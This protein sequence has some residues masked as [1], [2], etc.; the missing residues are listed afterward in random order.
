MEPIPAGEEHPDTRLS[1]GHTER[2]RTVGTHTCGQFEAICVLYVLVL[3]LQQEAGVPKQNPG[4]RRNNIQTPCEKAPRPAG[5]LTTSSEATMPT[6]ATVCHTKMLLIF[7]KK[8]NTSW[9]YKRENGH[10]IFG[11]AFKA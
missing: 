8:L 7:I 2:Q 5:E 6:T 1:Q 9:V 3:G 4:R 11:K 10:L